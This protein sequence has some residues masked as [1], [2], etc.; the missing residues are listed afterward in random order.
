MNWFFFDDPIVT[1]PARGF[2]LL[3]SLLPP[4]LPLLQESELPTKYDA[5]RVTDREDKDKGKR[6]SSYEVASNRLSRR[7]EEREWQGRIFEERKE[8]SACNYIQYEFWGN[9]YL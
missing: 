8:V 6:W 3:P 5:S 9:I 7:G 4:L 1:F 2:S